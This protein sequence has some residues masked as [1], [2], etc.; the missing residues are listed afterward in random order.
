M[1]LYGDRLI[2][3]ATDVSGHMACG[4]LTT[5]EFERAHGR[6]ARPPLFPDPTLEVLRA[7]GHEHEANV[8]AALEAEGR[9]VRRL[10]LPTREPESLARAAGTTL[11]A[12]REGVDLIYQGTLFD[13]VWRGHPDFLIRVEEPSELGAWS[14]EVLDAKLAREAKVGA[15]LQICFYTEMVGHA[16]GRLP[17][18]MH[19]ALGGPE[20]ARESLRVADYAAYYRSVRRR[21]ADAIA[22]PESRGTYPEPCAHCDLCE[23]SPE[24]DKQWRFDDHLSLVAGITRKQRRELEEREITT[25][26]ALGRLP[27]PLR[28]KLPSVSDAALAKV[29][30]QAR[31]QLEG[32]E[33][34]THRYELLRDVEP[35]FGLLALPAPSQSDL[36]F[37]IEGDPYALVGGLEYLFGWTDVTGAYTGRWALG[38]AE[39]K[40]AFEAFVDEAIRRFDADPGFHVYHFNHYEPTA[41]KKLAGRHAT[42][43]EELDRL[44]R[45]EIFVDL[46]RVV[47]QGLRASVESYSIKKLEPLYGFERAVEL[48]SASSAL[49]QFD[50]WL[51]LSGAS[52]DAG[53]PVRALI[54]G[55]NKDD[56]LSTLRLRGWLEDRRKELGSQLGGPLERPSRAQDRPSDDAAE[57]NERVASL[58]ARLTVDVP[59]ESAART[60]DQHGRWVLAQLLEWHRREWKS[61]WWE[62]FRLQALPSEE[63]IQERNA[64]GGLEYVG[65]V[66]T[67]KRSN[68]HRYRFPPQEHGFQLGDKPHDPA[69][70][71]PAGEIH[72][73]DDLAGTVDLKRGKTSTTPHPAALVPHDWISD[74]DLRESLLAFADEVV[75]RGL[76]SGADARAGLLLRA[77]PRAG[78]AEGEPLRGPSEP[79]LDAALRLGRALDRSALPIQGPP[80]AGKT[81]TGARMI[82]DLLEAGRRV[83]VTAT[84]HKVIGRLLEEVVAAARQQGVALR[85]AQVAKEGKDC[86]LPEIQIV[87]ESKDGV[88]LL[89]GGAVTLLAGTAWVWSRPDVSDSLDVLFVDEAGQMS[90]A[91]VLACA[92]AARSLV[93]LG[94]P[95]QLEQPQKG[96]HPPG[97]GVSALEYLAA[98]AS[99][100]PD[101]RGLFLDR[102]WRLHPDLCAFTSELYYEGRLQPREGLE[103][104]RVD[105]PEPFSGTG[106]RVVP[107][108][109]RG[110]S[111]ESPEEIEAVR[112]LV[113]RLLVSG[114]TWTKASGEAVPIELQD[115]L[116]VAPYNAQ[117][118]ALREA[119][120]ER[121]RV[122]TVDKF[123]GQEAPI[124]IFSPASSSAMDAPRGMEF[125]F[126]P[127]RLNVATSRARCVAMIVGSGELLEP[128]CSSVRQ[129][130][131]ANGFCW[132]AEIAGGRGLETV[133]SPN[134]L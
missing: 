87:E 60:P 96:V 84:S 11:A 109:H 19:L 94:D 85:A 115:I 52:G 5:L 116:I 24:C 17:D 41:L 51:G 31:L 68:L 107:V 27:L 132:L 111:N 90:L 112:K 83:G 30:E 123:Q 75:D 70:E 121:A 61:F 67:V 29:R 44:L 99:T 6:R 28:P 126:S 95:Q 100:L 38:R 55:Y 53:D 54:E 130:G 133:P 82:V 49:A 16:Q 118:N 104:Q 8:L 127:N 97:T 40:A 98:G 14:Y 86:G 48:R 37:D 122:G 22:G 120:P 63:L 81:Y 76:A 105:G 108:A 3:A 12:M 26:E 103:R 113:E 43:G 134:S 4:H 58:V 1:Y 64:L 62:Y 65:V 72:E 71:D 102:T 59:A 39:E 32:R 69:T 124:V 36:F 117:V 46:Y 35:G 88:A 47:R 93:L 42:R 45:G 9:T 13:G 23:W 57:L 66:G 73:I 106:L 77:A 33:R 2:C 10:E 21:F 128:R 131:L 91:N 110:N 34:K 50:A 74:K 101:D 18:R 20:G 15:V 7:R 25:L 79:T 92:R 89:T 114:A 80:G 129:M 119:L 56:C 125:L 78:Q